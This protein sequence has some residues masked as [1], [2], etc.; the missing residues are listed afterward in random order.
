M[1]RLGES[2]DYDGVMLTTAVVSDD[3]GLRSD[4]ERSGGGPPQSP[5]LPARAS[6]Y[7]HNMKNTMR[8]NSARRKMD[9]GTF[10]HPNTPTSHSRLVTW[11][12]MRIERWESNPV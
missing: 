7:I 1:C 9:E 8:I 6:A 5:V 11:D 2:G 12:M 3:S 10:S 4:S